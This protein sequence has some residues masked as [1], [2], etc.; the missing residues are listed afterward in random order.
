MARPRPKSRWR[1]TKTSLNFTRHPD[2]AHRVRRYIPGEGGQ[3]TPSEAPGYQLYVVVKQL[4]PGLLVHTSIWSS[5][6]PA[7]NCEHSA[8]NLWLAI[9]SPQIQ[10]GAVDMAAEVMLR[11]SQ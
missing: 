1:R 4:T 8:A 5:R 9:A 10:A 7:C 2:R 11:R 6:A 3:A